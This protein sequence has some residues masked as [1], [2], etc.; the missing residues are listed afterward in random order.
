MPE[1]DFDHG[2]D[3]ATVPGTAEYIAAAREQADL[4]EPVD[5]SELVRQAESDRAE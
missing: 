4:P 1:P 3:P 5:G 2:L